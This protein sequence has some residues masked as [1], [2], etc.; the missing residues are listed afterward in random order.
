LFKEEGA[1]SWRP[2]ATIQQTETNFIISAELPG[3][4]KE[5]VKVDINNDSLTIS[6]EKRI[7]D[8][9]DTSS[10]SIQRSYLR[11][12]ALPSGVDHASTSAKMENGLLTITIPKPSKELPQG[13]S[14][15]IQ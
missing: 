12:F 6:G 4:S 3:L 15:N 8:K 11:S 10:S 9:S 1:Q 14:I 7:E 13:V 2:K 5:D